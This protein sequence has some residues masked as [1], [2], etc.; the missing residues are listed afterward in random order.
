MGATFIVPEK[1]GFSLAQE[2][3]MN[4]GSYRGA[5]L[6]KEGFLLKCFPVRK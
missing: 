3:L 1:L 6:E 4:A 5:D 2:I